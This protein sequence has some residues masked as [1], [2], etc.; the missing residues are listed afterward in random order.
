MYIVDGWAY[1]DA[2]SLVF[3]T[4]EV[5]CCFHHDVPAVKYIKPHFLCAECAQDMAS[6]LVK[7]LEDVLEPPEFPNGEFPN[8]RELTMPTWERDELYSH[9]HDCNCA[10]CEGEPAEVDL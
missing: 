1:E 7:G 2:R 10:H 9:P 6:A 3:S 8:N 4:T 5:S